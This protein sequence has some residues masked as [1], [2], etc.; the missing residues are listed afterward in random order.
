MV[1]LALCLVFRNIDP[2]KVAAPGEPSDLEKGSVAEMQKKK[3][4]DWILPL[5]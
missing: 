4:W 1:L 5:A 3:I 2:S